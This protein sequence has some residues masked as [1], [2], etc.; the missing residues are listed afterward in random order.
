MGQVRRRRSQSGVKFSYWKKNFFYCVFGAPPS[1]LRCTVI[2][3]LTVHRCSSNS[4]D[5]VYFFLFVI[6]SVSLT[7]CRFCFRGTSIDVF[8]SKFGRSI[9]GSPLHGV[10][11]VVLVLKV[12]P[13]FSSGSACRANLFQR[14]N[15]G[16]LWTVLL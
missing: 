2:H 11:G 4:G 14:R 15:L 16:L 6:D 10:S 7:I 13:L 8:V 1:R 9:V 5:A 12:A 3:G